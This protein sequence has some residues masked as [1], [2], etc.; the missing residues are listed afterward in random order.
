MVFDP[1]GYAVTVSYAVLDA[2]RIEAKMRGG[3]TISAR[4][5]A[6]D[7]ETGLGVVKLGGERTWQAATLG[8]TRDVQ[9][10]TRTTTSRGSPVTCRPSAGFPGTGNTCWT[11]R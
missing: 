1:R 3:G 9:V 10:S 6:I 5:V 7:L 2:V 11:E 8:D 4:V